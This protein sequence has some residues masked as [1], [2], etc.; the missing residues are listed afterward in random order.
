MSNIVIL[1]KVNMYSASV[2]YV[3]NEKWAR[4]FHR[5][6]ASNTYSG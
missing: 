6:T 3:G 2:T 4:D 1:R 5:Q